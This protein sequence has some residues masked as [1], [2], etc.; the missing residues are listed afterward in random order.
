MGI[1]RRFCCGRALA[2]VVGSLC[3]TALPVPCSCD[4]HVFGNS[5]SWLKSAQWQTPGLCSIASNSRSITRISSG[6][7]AHRRASEKMPQNSTEILCESCPTSGITPMA[8]TTI[9]SSFPPG[10]A[11]ATGEACFFAYRRRDSIGKRRRL[12]GSVSRECYAGR[13][14]CY[15][16]RERQKVQL[17]WNHVLLNLSQHP[18]ATGINPE[19]SSKR[20]GPR[21][22]RSLD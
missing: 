1:R 5:L 22:L 21:R 14:K 12:V 15:P 2:G 20:Q 9:F 19:S 8:Q 11:D 7:L 6:L 3:R 4:K 18:R 13:R 10:F 16:G 17:S